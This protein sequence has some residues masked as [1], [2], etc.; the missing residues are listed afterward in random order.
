[1]LG[2]LIAIAVFVMVDARNHTASDPD[3]SDDPFANKR[4]GSKAPPK[5]RKLKPAERKRRKR[6]RAPRKR[7]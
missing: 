7:W 6:S 2:L 3:I 1:V 5:P 4:K